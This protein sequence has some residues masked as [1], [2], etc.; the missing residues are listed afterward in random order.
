M[1][2]VKSR[3]EVKIIELMKK[4]PHFTGIV[5][6][7]IVENWN[8]KAFDKWARSSSISKGEIIIAQFILGVCNP[9]FKWKVGKFD[10]F[11]AASTFDSENWEVI[12]EWC[13]KP[14]FL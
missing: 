7:K 6:S 8:D 11:E 5:P 10:I 14:F 12:V 1:T 3:Q 4:F 2:N 13:K 9:L